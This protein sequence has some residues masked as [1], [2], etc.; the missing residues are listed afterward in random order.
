MYWVYCFENKINGK[1]YIGK[2]TSPERRLSAHLSTAKKASKYQKYIHR[3]IAKHGIE[4]FWFRCIDYEMSEADAL[5]QERHWIKFFNTTDP[6]IGYNLTEGGEGKSSYK[7]TPETK[8]LL[9]QIAKQRV[10]KLNPFY[11]KSHSNTTINKLRIARSKLTASQ[12]D[13]LISSYQNKTASVKT[14]S[15]ELN[16][17]TSHAYELING[18]YRRK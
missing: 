10:G 8:Q 11:G 18:K 9:S 12:V 15:K 1:K 2:T 5:K 13:Y 6:N 17:S 4:N 7:H 16:I 14:L 3:A